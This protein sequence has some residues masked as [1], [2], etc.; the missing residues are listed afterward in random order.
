[1]NMC[2]VENMLQITQT[3]I[4]D[5]VTIH[6]KDIA[7]EHVF[8]E[9]IFEL[10]IMCILLFLVFLISV[11]VN[12]TILVAFY[13]KQSL[14]TI[15]NRWTILYLIFAMFAQGLECVHFYPQWNV[16]SFISNKFVLSSLFCIKTFFLFCLIDHSRFIVFQLHHELAGGEFV[17]QPVLPPPGDHGPGDVS[18]LPA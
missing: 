15:S 12:I 4:V 1:M 17:L 6:C 5:N 8:K 11:S 9:D 18:C 13:R 14:R 2:E 10:M 3:D 16:S 7:S